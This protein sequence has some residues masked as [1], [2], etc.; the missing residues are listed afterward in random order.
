M[1]ERA[2]VGD[3]V[4][5]FMNGW[6]VISTV[7]DAQ[8]VARPIH[9]KF[10]NGLD[11]KY[12]INGTLYPDISNQTLFWDEI[13]FDIPKK[14]LPKLEVDTKVIVWNNSGTKRKRYFHSFAEDGRI[15][16]WDC[17][18]TSFSALGHDHYATWPNWEL[19]EETK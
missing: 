1:F 13:K 4:W 19:Y 11:E 10:D 7:I 5:D 17:G 18:S 8:S 6:G 15:R 9:V 2:K 12:T 14:P 16:V 3:K